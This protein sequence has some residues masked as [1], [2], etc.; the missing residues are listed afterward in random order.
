MR[1]LLGLC[2]CR[3]DHASLSLQDYCNEAEHAAELVLP[4]S[5]VHEACED[6]YDYSNGVEGGNLRAAHTSVIFVLST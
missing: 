1:R 3:G 6:R 5:D 4:L 2:W